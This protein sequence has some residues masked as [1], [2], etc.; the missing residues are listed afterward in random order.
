MSKFQF[1]LQFIM[2]H[3]NKFNKDEI[4]THNSDAKKY[5]F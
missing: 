1:S 2:M 5:H 3:A 4:C